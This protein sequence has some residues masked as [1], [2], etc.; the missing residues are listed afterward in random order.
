M[1]TFILLTD[2]SYTN[3]LRF[4][5]SSIIIKLRIK[6]AYFPNQKI[7]LF[8]WFGNCRYEVIF[9]YEDLNNTEDDAHFAMGVSNKHIDEEKTDNPQDTHIKNN[10]L[11]NP[12]I[13]RNSKTEITIIIIKMTNQN[14]CAKLFTLN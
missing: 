5:I 7:S 9:L 3:N 6:K 13:L 2:V 11:F 12:L 1:S 14:N 8:E 4:I 10:L